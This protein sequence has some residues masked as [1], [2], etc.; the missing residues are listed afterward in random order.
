MRLRA[1]AL[2]VLYLAA[3]SWPASAALEER[4]MA[5]ERMQQPLGSVCCG[6]S[7]SATRGGRWMPS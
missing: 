4:L 7:S 5:P 1:V 2:L 6:R 3:M